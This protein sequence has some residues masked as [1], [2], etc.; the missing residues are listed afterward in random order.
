MP[1]LEIIMGNQSSGKRKSLQSIYFKALACNILIDI[2]L[3]I[4]FSKYQK[5]IH[6]EHVNLRTIIINWNSFSKSKINV[7]EVAAKLKLSATYYY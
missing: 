6:N 3:I 4:K 1:N 5:Y 7:N 2:N